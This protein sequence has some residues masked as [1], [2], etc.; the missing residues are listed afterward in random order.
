MGVAEL[1]DK[2]ALILMGS[3]IQRERLNR[4]LTQTEL[5]VHAGIGARTVRYL[6][7]G[8]QTTVQTLIRILR[9]LNKL[10]ALDAFL[11]DPGLSPLQ[12]AKLKGR[13]R[14]RAGGRR[15]KIRTSR[16]VTHGGCPQ[17]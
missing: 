6:E 11:P 15:R 17:S 7:A 12:L 3:R 13:E 9:A 10:D 4:N 5:A 16:G 2:A 8:R 14:K 1:T